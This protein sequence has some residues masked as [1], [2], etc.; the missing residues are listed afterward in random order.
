M[1]VFSRSQLKQKGAPIERL[2][3]SPA[4]AL[5]STIAMP[6]KRRIRNAALLFYDFMLDEGEQ[7]IADRHYIPTKKSI[8]NPLRNT[9]ITFID[10]GHN[11]DMNDKWIK[12]YDE[13]I[14]KRT[15][16]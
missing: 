12:E 13:V 14:V 16:P 15:K 2:I 1:F 9:Q 11:L 10:P 7:I 4:I 5:F 6:K 8:E 3:L